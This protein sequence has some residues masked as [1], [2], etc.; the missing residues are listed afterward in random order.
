MR[1]VRL[2]L[3]MVLVVSGSMLAKEI[4]VTVADP[5]E[6]DNLD[7]H[8]TQNA[9]NWSAIYALY[10]GLVRYGEDET[11]VY[12]W[13][14]KSW[15]ASEDGLKWTFHL[16]DDVYFVDGTHLDASVVKFSF[17]RLLGIGRG[18]AEQ[19]REIK[20]IKVVDPLT[21]QFILKYPF[22]PF[23]ATL[24]SDF[25]LIVPPT[26]MEHEV[27]GD[28]GTKWLATHDLGS[29]PF[30]LESWERGQ[31]IVLKANKNHW[32]GGPKVDKVIL[33]EIKEPA[34]LK[35]ELLAGTVDIVTSG[36]TTEDLLELLGREDVEVAVGSSYSITYLVFQDQND[37][38]SPFHDARVRRAVAYAIDYDA[39]IN[40]LHRGLVEHFQGLI[41]KGMFGRVPVLDDLYH[42]NPT[43]SKLLLEEAGYPNG[44]K[45]TLR[46]WEPYGFP[47]IAA[48]V[49]RNLAEV[50]I[51]VKIET[52]AFSTMLTMLE[53]RKAG[54]AIMNIVPDYPDPDDYAWVSGH[55]TALY[56]ISNYNNPVYDS[57][58]DKARRSV[59]I[60]ERTK[61]YQQA[62][63][64]HYEMC[65]E[66]FLFQR[67]TYHPY[68]PR[69]KGYY[70][71]AVREQMPPFESIWVED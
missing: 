30:R 18:P 23:L 56:N 19:F 12:P 60:E 51:K 49:Q 41:P 69:I 61:L 53:E 1:L 5:R 27:N 40:G 39:V 14:A 71:N 28:W 57:I 24:A 44:F 66:V 16:R 45:T 63:W 21:V 7:P 10:D 37:P 17:E 13:V 67:K 52:Y 20:E 29:G 22:A 15:E 33:R 43:L 6:F 50:G 55:S 11:K 36:L 46:C 8:F 35:M 31:R 4:V 3:V 59:D 54:F 48:I 58:V 62:Q 68:L 26:V 9:H 2:V 65:P 47:D 25:A 64:I 42:H 70:V 38:N 32:S 34:T